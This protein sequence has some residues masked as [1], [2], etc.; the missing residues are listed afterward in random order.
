[1]VPLTQVPFGVYQTR[2]LW[3]S[4]L[5]WVSEFT[6]LCSHCRRS[7][8]VRRQALGV[9]KAQV[10]RAWRGVEYTGQVLA[11][12]RQ[13]RRGAPQCVAGTSSVFR[14]SKVLAASRQ[15]RRGAPHSVAGTSFEVQS[16]GSVQAV[17]TWSTAVRQCVRSRLFEV[18]SPGGVQAV[19]T[20]SP[21]ALRV[22]LFEVQFKSPGG[23][24]ADEA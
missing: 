5:G 4:Y 18:Q 3:R 13:R 17:T 23:V 16:P 24:Q 10:N 8:R 9:A 15:Q 20:W 11:A 22:R 19:T 6:I 12:S 21:A 1:M 14:S 2:S 7:G